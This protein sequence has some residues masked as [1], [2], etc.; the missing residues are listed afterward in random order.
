[1]NSPIRQPD[2]ETH[3]LPDQSVL[4]FGESSG[5]AVPVNESGARIW[6]LCDGTRTVDEIIEELTGFYDAP[7]SQVDGD[8][9]QF[10]SALIELGLLQDSVSL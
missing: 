10:V 5:A 1:M 4:L 9:R 6:A 3:R 8:V 2:V 7:R